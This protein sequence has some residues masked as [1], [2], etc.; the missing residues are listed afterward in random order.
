MKTNYHLRFK[1]S[2]NSEL[3]L[4][5]CQ[6]PPII[7]HHSSLQNKDME[8][9]HKTYSKFSLLQ[10]T[11]DV[12]SEK[13]AQKECRVDKERDRKI[14]AGC[15]EL[16]SRMH[17]KIQRSARFYPAGSNQT[18]GHISV[19]IR[20]SFILLHGLKRYLLSIYS[21]I[22]TKQTQCINSK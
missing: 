13:K 9:R 3:I 21:M 10:E 12:Q 6:D 15:C 22:L 18:T 16:H 5:L 1:V 11:I 19:S 20:C 4:W 2:P 14:G 8:G 17:N 7:R